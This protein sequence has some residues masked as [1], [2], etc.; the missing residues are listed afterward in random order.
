MYFLVPPYN[1]AEKSSAKYLKFATV[2][3]TF[4]VLLFEFI[5]SIFSLMIGLFVIYP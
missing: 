5:R 3:D 2:K 1:S 4:D